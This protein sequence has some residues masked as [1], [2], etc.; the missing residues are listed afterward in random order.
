MPSP[1]VPA[2]SKPARFSLLTV[3]QLIA[4]AAYLASIPVFASFLFG[5]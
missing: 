4:M 5:A 2:P 1:Y 3:P